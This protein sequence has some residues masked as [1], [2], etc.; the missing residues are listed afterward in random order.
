MKVY[1]PPNPM[2]VR[3]ENVRLR[4]EIDAAKAALR[5]QFAM[6]ALTGIMSGYG[7]DAFRAAVATEKEAADMAYQIADAMLEARQ[8]GGRDDGE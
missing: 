3:S 4:R 6:A 1:G 7:T 2:D 5:D 8:V